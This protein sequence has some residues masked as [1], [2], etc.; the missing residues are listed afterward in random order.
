MIAKVIRIA[1][2]D[3]ATVIDYAYVLAAFSM[4]LLICRER[5]LWAA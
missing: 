4:K 2:D 3:E 5:N 1:W